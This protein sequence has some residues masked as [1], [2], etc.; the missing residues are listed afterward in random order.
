[1][2]IAQ[3][4]HGHWHWLACTSTALQHPDILALMGLLAA[5]SRLSSNPFSVLMQ[6]SEVKWV[7]LQELREQME[8]APSEFTPWFTGE[9]WQV[10]GSC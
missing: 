8:I 4:I 1:V 2:L 7:G 5:P 6:V 10:L 3:H 9:V